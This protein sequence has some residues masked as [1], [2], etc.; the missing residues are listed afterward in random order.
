MKVTWTGVKARYGRPR[1]DSGT[2]VNCR[3]EAL[4]HRERWV[5]VDPTERKETDSVWILC[6]GHFDS[7]LQLCSHQKISKA[8]IFSESP[9]NSLLVRHAP[10]SLPQTVSP[11]YGGNVK[12]LSSL[13]WSI[14]KKKKLIMC[15]FQ[16]IMGPQNWTLFFTP[17]SASVPPTS[18]RC[19]VALK[20][21]SSSILWYTYLNFL[22]CNHDSTSHSL[23]GL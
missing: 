10:V 14:K 23:T 15:F 22:P 11:L 20:V 1:D 4:Q 16:C 21:S 12:A 9:N 13:N 2:W 3:L 17:N 6:G 8:G 5:T 19:Y 18:S 7:P